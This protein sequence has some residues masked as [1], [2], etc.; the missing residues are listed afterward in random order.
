MTFE[1][2]RVDAV[3]RD[4]AAGARL[5]LVLVII[6]LLL[7]MVRF[8]FDSERAPFAAVRWGDVEDRRAI[9][10]L[11]PLLGG[12]PIRKACLASG[13]VSTPGTTPEATTSVVEAADAASVAVVLLA[14]ASAAGGTKLCVEISCRIAAKLFAA[15][16]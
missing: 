15:S 8:E 14:A 4:V 11:C 3:C 13:P 7:R 16:F 9:R 2:E 10:A 12:T 6:L 5:F 1:R